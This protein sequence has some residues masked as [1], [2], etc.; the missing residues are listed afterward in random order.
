VLEEANCAA[1]A[2][3]GLGKIQILMRIR[4]Q[5]I[6]PYTF[7]SIGE[8]LRDLGS[9]QPVQSPYFAG[10]GVTF[11]VSTWIFQSSPSRITVQY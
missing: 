4:I 2:N 5:E 11:Q 1:F 8:S 10:D 3:H 6:F 9:I 7:V